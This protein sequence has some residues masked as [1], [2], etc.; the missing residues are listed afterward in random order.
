MQNGLDQLFKNENND[1]AF[2]NAKAKILE[3]A[4]SKNQIF[5]FFSLKAQNTL[6]V[7]RFQKF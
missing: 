2:V 5:L 3:T 6:C 7:I 1:N 4:A